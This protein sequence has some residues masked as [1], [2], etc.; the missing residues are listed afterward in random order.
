[1]GML[2][3]G[4]WQDEDLENFQRSDD[5]VRFDSGFAE[6]VKSNFSTPYTPESNRYLLYVNATCPWSHR[7][8]ITH[9]LKGL[10]GTVKTVLLEPAMG[11]QSWWFGKSKNYRDPAINATHLHELYTATDANFTGRVS[12]PVLWDKKTERIINNDSA[13]ISRMLNSEF[14]EFAKNPELDFYPAQFIEELD[15]FNNLIADKLNDGIYR[16][17]LARSQELYEK[18]FDSIF[19]TLDYLEGKLA[20]NRYLVTEFP[21]EPDWRFFAFLIRFDAVYYSLYRCNLRRIA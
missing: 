12:I 15:H 13:K 20:T 6:E 9:E 18:A 21:T 7:T 10:S 1:M 11:C 14:N 8:T 19:Q 16:C 5:Q 3:K 4:S 17:L 2:V